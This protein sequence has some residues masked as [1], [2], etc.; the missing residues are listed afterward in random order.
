MS[1]IAERAVAIGA[2]LAEN[3][4]LPHQSLYVGSMTN[5]ITAP[6]YGFAGVRDVIAWARKF[7]TDIIISLSSYGGSGE[8]QTTVE[9]GGVPV[10]VDTNIGTAQA[11]ELGRILQREL[12]R[13]VSIHIGAEELLAAIDQLVAS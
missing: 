12:N 10:G 2:A 3:P 1:T 13:D 4:D 7:N 8:V 5:S 6:G 9:L 11:Y